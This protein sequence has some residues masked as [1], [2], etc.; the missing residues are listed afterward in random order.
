M[1][2]PSPPQKSSKTKDEVVREI[3]KV[4][5]ELELEFEVFEPEQYGFAGE[6]GC[7]ANG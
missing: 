4:L 5:S 6:T 3:R 1:R 2:D 7:Y